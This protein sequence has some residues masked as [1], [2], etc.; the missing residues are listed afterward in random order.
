M[1]NNIDHDRLFK[2][3][4]S[5]FFVEF[6]ELFF[7]QLIDYLDRESITFLDKEVFTDVTEGERYE[8][9]LVAQVKFRGKESFFLIHLEAQESSRKWFN[10]R[11]S[12]MKNTSKCNCIF[13]N[14]KTNSIV[15]NSDTI[16]II[17][18]F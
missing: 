2:E 3:L 17:F 14:K 13:F 4:I 5:T 7:P 9:D 6:I 18:S 12:T 10:W 1:T 11:F 16:G 8:S 15:T